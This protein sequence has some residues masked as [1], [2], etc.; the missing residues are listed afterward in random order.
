MREC[1]RG[2]I[3]PGSGPGCTLRPSAVTRCLLRASCAACRRGWGSS[4]GLRSSIWPRPFRKTPKMML[5]ASAGTW[6]LTSWRVQSR[7]PV[8][9]AKWFSGSCQ[10][11]GGAGRRPWRGC[12]APVRRGRRRR[13]YAGRRE[14]DGAAAVVVGFDLLAEEGESGGSGHGR[15]QD[16]PPVFGGAGI[17]LVVGP[18]L[19]QE[20]AIEL[21]SVQAVG[22]RQVARLE[23]SGGAARLV[24]RARG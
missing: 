10:G 2:G 11:S 22:E 23:P 13:W 1:F 9:G 19:A 5:M 12:G 6:A 20:G 18:G 4:C 15:G 8:T 24:Q 17:V 3:V 14:G 16:H 21:P 7:V